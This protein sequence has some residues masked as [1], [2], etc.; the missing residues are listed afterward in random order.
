[1][2]EIKDTNCSNYSY[3]DIYLLSHNCEFLFCSLLLI[4]QDSDCGGDMLSSNIN[5]NCFCHPDQQ[6][7]PFSLSLSLS[8]LHFPKAV[9]MCNDIFMYYL[10][11]ILIVCSPIG[12]INNN[13]DNNN[14]IL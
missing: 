10:I 8:P 3:P 11:V 5:L 6:I 7:A 9:C 4:F 12:Q 1:M 2:K 14:N 13:N